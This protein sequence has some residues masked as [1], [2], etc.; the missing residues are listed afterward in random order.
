[1]AK[2]YDKNPQGASAGVR[3][4][5]VKSTEAAGDPFGADKPLISD[6]KWNTKPPAGLS[7]TGDWLSSGQASSVGSSPKGK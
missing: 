6:K 7:L 4:N 2:S 1:M 3:V 5:P